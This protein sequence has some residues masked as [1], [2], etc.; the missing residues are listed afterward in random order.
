LLASITALVAMIDS[1][2]RQLRYAAL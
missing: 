1:Y 2:K